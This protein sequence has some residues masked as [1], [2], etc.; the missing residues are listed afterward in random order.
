M[1]LTIYRASS[2][3]SSKTSLLKDS[4][5]KSEGP[6]IL[7]SCEMVLI[8]LTESLILMGQIIFDLLQN[9]KKL[10]AKKNAFLKIFFLFLKEIVMY[11]CM[12][13]MQTH[14]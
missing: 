10:M 9:K 7:L 2:L 5:S 4:K 3:I 8:A 1:S 13:E 6:A 14:F 11:A 12:H